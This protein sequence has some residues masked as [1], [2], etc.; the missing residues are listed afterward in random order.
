MISGSQYDST[1]VQF[2]APTTSEQRRTMTITARVADER[3]SGTAQANVVVKQ[4]ALISARQLPDVL[5]AQRSDR[6]NNCGKRVLLEELH[7]LT[8][9]D[10][11]GRV[12][13]VG[14]IA[15]AERASKE[16]DMRRALNAAATISAGQGVCTAFPASQILVNAAGSADNGVR[17]QPNFCSGSTEAAERPGQAV[18]ATDDAAKYQRVEVWFVPSG[19]AL[20]PSAQNAKDAATQGVAKLGCPR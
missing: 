9:S 5:F 8:Q 19:G 17:L 3:G 11:M 20:P 6:V 7:G 13:L 4:K 15:E 1:G 14:H 18:A 10:P 12:V 2:A 16:L